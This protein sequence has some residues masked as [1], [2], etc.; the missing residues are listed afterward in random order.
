M[1]LHYLDNSATTP[2][3]HAAKNAMLTV[4]N[5]NFG[6]PSSL[7]SIGVSA[8]EARENARSSVLYAISGNPRAK[9]EQLIFT[10]GGTEANNIALIGAVTAKARNKGKKIIV[11]ASEHASILNTAAH[12]AVLGYKVVY[13]DT[14]G[15]VWDY[16]AYER[17]VDRDTILVSAMLVNNETG[18]VNDIDRIAATARDRNPDVIIHTDAVQ[19]FM[20]LDKNLASLDADLISVSGHK[21]GAPKGIGALYQN[22][23]MVKTRALCPIIFGGGQEKGMRS[24]TENMIGIVGFGAATEYHSAN[25]ADFSVKLSSLRAYLGSQLIAMPQIH[26]NTPQTE[27]KAKHI[28]SVTVPGI[29]SETMLHHLS[30]EGVFVSSGSA[31]SSN[32]SH[33]DAALKSFGLSDDEADCTIRISLS[34]TNTTDDIDALISAMQSG[35]DRLVR[36]S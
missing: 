15:G 12:L 8:E 4:M 29:K 24:G 31:C 16:Q 13:I 26:V 34:E 22:E 33:T 20:K 18:A 11:G 27:R 23:R 30:S 17:A 7:H 3:N 9:A 35:I 21:I 14:P 5:E 19:G 6:N 32:G 25:F 36:K 1:A 10:S 28:V 2:L